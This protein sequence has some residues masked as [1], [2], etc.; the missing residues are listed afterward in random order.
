M[1]VIWHKC[2]KDGHWCSPEDLNLS[3]LGKTAGVYIIWH[4]GDPLHAVRPGQGDPIS[5]R[6]AAHRNDEEILA[7][8]TYCTLRVTWAPMAWE[9]R[10][11]V[12]RYLAETWFPLVGAAYPDVQPLAVNSPW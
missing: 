5:D 12:E 7:Y 4:E 2:G 6:L 9:Y 1:N 8:G 11:E 10:D 3:T